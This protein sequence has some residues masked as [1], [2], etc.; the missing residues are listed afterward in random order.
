MTVIMIDDILV[1][2]EA[3]LLVRETV[4]EKIETIDE[5]E[6]TDEKIAII[7]EKS[8]VRETGDMRRSIKVAVDARMDHDMFLLGHRR[9]APCSLGGRHRRRRLCALRLGTCTHTHTCFH[10]CMHARMHTCMHA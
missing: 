2:A 10:P 8:M 4:D 6:N 5:I 1:S 3:K 9:R 7:D